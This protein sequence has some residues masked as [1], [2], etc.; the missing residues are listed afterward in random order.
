M[1]N[2]I[3]LLQANAD[4]NA[5]SF[6]N[7]QQQAAIA[8]A[9]FQAGLAPRL[10]WL[11]A[12]VAVENMRPVAAEFEN[13]IRNLKGNFAIILGL[14][15][16]TE[17][18][19]EPISPEG[20]YISRDLAEFISRSAA[21]GKPDIMELQANITTLQSQRRAL[22]L[23]QHTPFLRLG[24]T[25]TSM[26]NP[27]LDPFQ[28]NL[29][30]GDNWNRGGNFSVTLGMSFNGL[31]PFTREGQQLRDMD[32]NLQIQNIMLAQMSKET[33]L[34]IFNKISSL[35]TIRSSLAA[36]QAA[37]ELAE[38]TYTLTEEAYRAGHQDFQS[39]R[40]SAFALDQARLQ[41][42]SQHF[43]FMNDLIDLEYSLGIPFGTLS[44]VN[45]SSIETSTREY[46]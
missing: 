20:I 16:D 30:T 36:L 2:S 24:W 27:M 10:S 5:E 11:Q 8:E 15:F 29:F 42:L 18:E 45:L 43:S 39:V 31:L 35:E 7:A 4:L 32:A 19:L 44:S 14:P 38:M 9:N 33:E 21:M 13:S 17:F 37:V 46:R 12:Q 26:F 6:D 40:N 23:Q 34:E 28:D 1:Y 41:L 22:G 25:L 3:L